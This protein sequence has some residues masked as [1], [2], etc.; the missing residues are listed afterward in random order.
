MDDGE[1]EIVIESTDASSVEEVEHALTGMSVVRWEP[2]RMIDPMTI[3]AVAGSLTA[4]VNGLLSLRDRLRARPDAPRVV[5]RD[6]DGNEVVL[7]A[8]T[9]EQLRALIAGQGEGSTT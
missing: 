3:L 7:V 4:L 1:L 8:A 6:A 9:P 2:Q 5:V